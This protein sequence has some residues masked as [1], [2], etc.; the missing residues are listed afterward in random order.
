MICRVW[1]QSAWWVELVPDRFTP[2]GDHVLD[3]ARGHRRE[4]LQVAPGLRGASHRDFAFRVEGLLAADRTEHDR[5]PP[6]HAEHLDRRIDPAD[7]HQP[8]RAHR[9]AVEPVTIRA[10]RRVVVGA[11]HQVAPMRDG[12]PRPRHGL[13]VEDVERLARRR[14]QRGVLRGLIDERQRLRL[15]APGAG[16]QAGNRR[17]FDPGGC[18]ERAGG[19][20]REEGASGRP[21]G[22]RHGSVI[23]TDGPLGRPGWTAPRT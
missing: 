7:V 8:A 9:V 12:D 4:H 6:A 10:N 11:R 16:E 15:V 2:R 17:A 19:D 22:W 21:I 13:E 18:Q 3:R 1:F 20:K 5:R 23:L 14:D